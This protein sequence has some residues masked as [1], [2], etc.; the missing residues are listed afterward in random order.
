MKRGLT[1]AEARDYVGV[2]RRTFDHQWRPLLTA[3]HQGTTLIF[4]RRDLDVL[5]D[6]FKRQTAANRDEV[7]AEPTALKAAQNAAWN[8]RPIVKKGVNLWAGKQGVSTPVRTGL[9]RLTGG[10]EALDFASV[11]SKVLRKQSAG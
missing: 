1:Y 5:F 10:G 2:K 11:A 3:L 8:G 9:G 7:A 4:D 6:R